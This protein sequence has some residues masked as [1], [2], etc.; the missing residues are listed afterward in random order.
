M[1]DTLAWALTCARGLRVARQRHM[2]ALAQVADAQRAL[3]DLK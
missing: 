2:E 1:K 3:L